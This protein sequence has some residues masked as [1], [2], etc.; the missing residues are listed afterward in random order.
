MS[1]KHIT[2]ANRQY[3]I[4]NDDI[5]KLYDKDKDVVAVILGSHGKQYWTANTS[6]TKDPQML[7]HPSII[8]VVMEGG[9]EMVRS[10]L[11]WIRDDLKVNIAGFTNMDLMNLK[12]VWLPAGTKFNIV[13]DAINDTS[14][15]EEQIITYPNSWLFT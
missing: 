1:N 13:Y 14:P 8:K 12:V 6:V 2:I 9:F 15:Y 3:K 7:F 4:I 5:N 11:D 10:N